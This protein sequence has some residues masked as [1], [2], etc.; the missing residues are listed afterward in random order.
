M[1]A[2]TNGEIPGEEPVTQKEKV[3]IILD[4]GSGAGLP[5]FMDLPGENYNGILSANEYLTRV[6]L[7]GANTDDADTPVLRGRRVAVI[8]GGN[9]A[10]DSVRTSLRLGA[11]RAIIVYRR[12]EVEM[13]ARVEEVQ[14]AKKEGVEFMT[15][16]NPVEY[17]ADKNGRV[18]RM[19]CNRMGLGE[20]DSSGRR[21]PP[22][23][24]E[25]SA[26]ARAIG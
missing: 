1:G 20:P 5:R 21:A 7:M 24:C 26:F 13:P 11:E 19:R 12:S 25:V 14:H 18:N 2:L 4:V 22:R 16:C 17:F 10:M 3:L 9:T 8:G 6:N 15:L 23:R